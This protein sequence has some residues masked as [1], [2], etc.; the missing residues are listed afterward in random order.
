MCQFRLRFSIHGYRHEFEVC[1][2]RDRTETSDMGRWRPASC[3]RFNGS[4]RVSEAGSAAKNRHAN[5]SFIHS[6]CQIVLL[7]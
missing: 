5:A 4:R 2:I 1:L 6:V 3:R 7:R